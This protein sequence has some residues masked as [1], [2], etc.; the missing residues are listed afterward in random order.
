MNDNTLTVYID[1]ETYQTN[2][3][4]ANWDLLKEEINKTVADKGKLVSLLSPEESVKK[5]LQREFS[6]SNGAIYF[7]E[8]RLHEDLSRRILDIMHE[9]LDVG[10]WHSFVKNIF[11]NPVPFAR[12]ELYDF[13]ESSDLPITPDGCFLAY[14]IVK[15]DYSDLWSGTIYNYIGSTV[16]MPGGRDAVDSIRTNTC[17]RG[18]HFCSKGYLTAYGAVTGTR[19]L[20]LKINPADVVSIPVDYNFAKGRTWKYQVIGEMVREQAQQYTWRPIDDYNDSWDDYETEDEYD[21]S[22]ER[23]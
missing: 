23:Y 17:S 7:G 10:P 12:Q 15:E 11:A 3:A 16:T 9:D 18:L 14:K 19:V 20:V 2:R 21:Y 1:G 13:L 6:V 4:T 5:S 8:E 22:E